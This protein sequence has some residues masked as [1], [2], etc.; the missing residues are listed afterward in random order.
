MKLLLLAMICLAGCVSLH[1]QV[2]ENIHEGDS[3][4]HVVDVLGA[5][6]SFLPSQRIE[7]AIA[8]YY[9]RRGDQCG[10]AIKDQKVRLIGC[11]ARADYVNPFAAML[12]GM[13]KGLQESSNNRSSF[14]HTSGTT[15]AYGHTEESTV[16]N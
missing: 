14:C 10:F 6:N 4:E 11:E 7:G 9:V 15:N 8:W 12:Q 16:C 3:S 2:Y 13:G 1:T 5:P